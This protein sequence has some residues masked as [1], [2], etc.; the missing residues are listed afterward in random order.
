MRCIHSKHIQWEYGAQMIC[1]DGHFET[2]AAASAAEKN[3][4][5]I[6]SNGSC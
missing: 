3:H 5:E 2:K 4:L 1:F 6:S